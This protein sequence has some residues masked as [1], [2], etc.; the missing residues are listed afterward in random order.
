MPDYPEVIGLL[1]VRNHCLFT[2]RERGN[3]RVVEVSEA[4]CEVCIEEVRGRGYDVRGT[5]QRSAREHKPAP[6]KD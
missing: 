1:R 5:G 3:R 4:H 2:W 6:A